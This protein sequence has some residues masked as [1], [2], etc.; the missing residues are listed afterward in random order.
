MPRSGCGSPALLP[1]YVCTHASSLRFPANQAGVPNENP[2]SVV[3]GEKPPAGTQGR[4][5]EEAGADPLPSEKCRCVTVQESLTEGVSSSPL[6]RLH[7]V[8]CNS[9]LLIL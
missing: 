3:A 5:A 6:P 7:T 1:R 2:W 8:I 9:K 4:L